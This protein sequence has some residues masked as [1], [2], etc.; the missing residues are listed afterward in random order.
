MAKFDHVPFDRMF[1]NIAHI[2][3]SRIFASS[4]HVQNLR[5]AL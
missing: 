5:E 1:Y 2:G 4:R 3:P